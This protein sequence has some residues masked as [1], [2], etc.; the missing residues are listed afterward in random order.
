MLFSQ[1]LSSYEDRVHDIMTELD[2]L[3]GRFPSFDKII[4]KADFYFH[5]L[6]AK[7]QKVL[8]VN[9]FDVF[10]NFINHKYERKRAALLNMLKITEKNWLQRH[11]DKYFKVKHSDLPFWP[12]YVHLATGFCC[13][14]FSS[15]Y[16]LYYIHS[17][18]LSKILARLD[19]SG[20]ALLC[21]G[22]CFPAYYYHFYCDVVLRN[23]YLT[24]NCSVSLLVFFL[25]IS[26]KFYTPDYIALRGV[27]F[28]SMGATT[29]IPYFHIY[30]DTGLIGGNSFDINVTKYLL[31]MFCYV[32]GTIIYVIRFPESKWPGSFDFIGEFMTTK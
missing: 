5:K 32:S 19:Y 6:P 20:I 2:E 7:V 16:H 30:L 31:G 1:N 4:Q 26:D 10:V 28:V 23:T 3:K 27:T 8:N 25:S 17:T 29:M 14:L 11:L 24:L 18:W 9:D 21:A 12:I 13:M 15:M 22:S